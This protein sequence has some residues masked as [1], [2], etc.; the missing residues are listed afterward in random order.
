MNVSIRGGGYRGTVITVDAIP[1][2]GETVNLGKYEGI[3]ESVTHL[4]NQYRDEHNANVSAEITL[5]DVHMIKKD[6]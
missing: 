1:R 5:R 3:V 2:V 6:D 4:P